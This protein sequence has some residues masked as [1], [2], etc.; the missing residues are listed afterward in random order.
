MAW[1]DNDMAFMERAH[2]DVYDFH[3]LSTPF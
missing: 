3:L 2:I 1:P